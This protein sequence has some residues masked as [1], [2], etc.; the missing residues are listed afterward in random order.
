VS[1]M[2]NHRKKR[3]LREEALP[4]FKNDCYETPPCATMA[5]IRRHPKLNMARKILDPVAGRGAMAK[6]LETYAVK[7]YF[8][9]RGIDGLVE[10][11]EKPTPRK[12]ICSDLRTGEHIYG[13]Q[14]IDFMTDTKFYSPE[15]HRSVDCACFN[16][17]FSP[18]GQ[19][20][21]GAKIIKRSLD[22][23]VDG[24]SVYALQRV[25]FLEGSN[26]YKLIFKEEGLKSVGIFGN[27]LQFHPE[28]FT[29]HRLSGQACHAWFEFEV[30]YTG[31]PVLYWF[32][33]NLRQAYGDKGFLPQQVGVCSYCKFKRGSSECEPMLDFGK[34][35][36]HGK[37]PMARYLTD[38]ETPDGDEKIGTIGYYC[39]GWMSMEV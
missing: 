8:G 12:V 9:R 16:P 35:D 21:L 7:R 36:K 32:E 38:P 33:E 17:P 15:R 5:L 6:V 30:G 1:G 26:R 2:G 4:V 23:V 10:T 27:R 20:N 34:M 3:T 39:A 13:K 22:F 28:G 29:D 24:G 11:G 37:F 19:A 18:V 14:G 25:Q 31:D